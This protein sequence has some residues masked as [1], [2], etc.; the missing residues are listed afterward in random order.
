ML[1]RIMLLLISFF[2][3]IPQSMT[4]FAEEQNQTENEEITESEEITSDEEVPP[5]EPQEETEQ[6]TEEPEPVPAETDQPAAS[7]EE[8]E[9][10]DGIM[11]TEYTT[12]EYKFEELNGSYVKI[13]EYYG[14]D[15]EVIVPSVYGEF[16][17]SEIA[18]S[19]FR[20]NDKITKVT[21]PGTITKIGE[22][23]FAN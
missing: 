20:D 10:A 8:P 11:A 21:I 18:A 6:S 2:L 3:M 15:S 14:T 9:P 22:Y 1:R 4:V 13:T 12:A 7:P 17:V 5:E 19:V 23:C 16:T